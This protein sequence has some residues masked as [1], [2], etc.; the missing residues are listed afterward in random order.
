MEN[1][2]RRHARQTTGPRPATTLSLSVDG[3]PVPVLK[4]HDISPLGIGLLISGRVENGSAVTL[5][6]RFGETDI[7][8]S[9]SVVWNLIDGAKSIESAVGIYF[10][11]KQMPL[12]M[13]FFNTLTA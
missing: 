9:G 13:E 7:T 2:R 10:D 11:E 1:D 12:N 6:Y 5:N 4:I 8:V 3:R